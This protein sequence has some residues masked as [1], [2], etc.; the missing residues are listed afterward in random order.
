M[1]NAISSALAGGT[2]ALYHTFLRDASSV[3][4]TT[5]RHL[6]PEGHWRCAGARA[7]KGARGARWL[8]E[9]GPRRVSHCEE[10]SLR[11]ERTRPS[12]HSSRRGSLAARAGVRSELQHALLATNTQLCKQRRESRGGTASGV[13]AA[14]KVDEAKLAS[15]V[16]LGAVVENSLRVPAQRCDGLRAV[17][18]RSPSLSRSGEMCSAESPE[19]GELSRLKTRSAGLPSPRYGA[20][21]DAALAFPKPTRAKSAKRGSARGPEI[22][23]ATWRVFLAAI[24]DGD[25]RR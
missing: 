2:S 3:S 10:K 6:R 15:S 23:S 18:S 20:R 24:V 17:L 21:V 14:S 12:A 19:F 25:D 9:C 8:E 16:L 7:R 5:A 13:S 11:C 1:L 22:A 4:E